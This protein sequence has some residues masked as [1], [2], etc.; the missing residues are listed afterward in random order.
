S[1][2]LG[3]LGARL[4]GFLAE[5]RLHE[6]DPPDDAP[7]TWGDFVIELAT[8]ERTLR[9][10]FDG[11]GTEGIA[12]DLG[13]LAEMDPAAWSTVR[14]VAAPCLRLLRLEHAVQQ[15]WDAHRLEQQPPAIV[16]ETIHLAVSRRDYRL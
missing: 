7:P 6:Q 5:T 14:L 12:I 16:Q 15:H 3:E 2:T 10:V 4:P 11:P 9:E 8:L 1:Y 13:A